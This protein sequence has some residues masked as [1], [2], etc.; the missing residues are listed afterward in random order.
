MKWSLVAGA[1]ILTVAGILTVF[2]AS[3]IQRKLEERARQAVVDYLE[4]HFDAKVE[5]QALRL[6]TPSVSSYSLLMQQGRG[7]LA[8]VDGDQLVLYRRS[9]PAS[10]PLFRIPHFRFHLDLGL[11]TS[12]AKNV[13]RV[14]IEGMEINIPPKGERPEMSTPGQRT[15][16]AGSV[17]FGEIQVTRCMLVL[18]PRDH[19]KPPLRFDIDNLLLNDAGPATAM[20][21]KARLTN[22]RPPGRI[23]AAGHFGPWNR[24]EPGDTPLD[25]DYRFNH[26]DLSI[27][28]GI[29]GILTSTGKFSGTLDEINVKGEA[30]VP[31][32]ALKSAG[33][34]VPLVTEFEAL[35]DGTNGNTTLMPVKALLG[36]RTRFVTSGAIIK[37][38]EFGKRAITLTVNMKNGELTDLL[39]LGTKGDAFMKGALQMNSKISIPP[40]NKT[41]REKLG[42]IGDFA[43]TDGMFLKDSIQ[44]KMDDLSRRGQGQPKNPAI[45]NVVYNMHGHFNMQNENMNLSGLAFDVP[46]AAVRLDGSYDLAS[47]ALDFHG[48]LRLDAKLSQTM[49]GWKRWVAKPLDPFFEKNGAGTL[50]KIKITGTAA[51]PSFGLDH[52]GGPKSKTATP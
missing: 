5:F 31:D 41:V 29:S 13:P 3:H 38:E 12:A 15:G 39:R 37:H 6:H 46:G 24:K 33:N 8:T 4:R 20:T 22:P 27:F 32:F 45:D 44:D 14:E 21:Y 35:V 26:A 30:G 47:D 17:S 2:S 18:L 10:P 25:G 43:I 40:Q 7:V 52:G 51:N 28:S 19:T 36:K 42:L 50:L 11:L 23:D 49:T 48:E 9:N 34:A 16:D 1:S